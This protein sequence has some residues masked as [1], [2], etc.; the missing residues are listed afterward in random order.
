MQTRIKKLKTKKK[1]ETL[2]TE[3]KYFT[4]NKELLETLG[5]LLSPKNGVSFRSIFSLTLITSGVFHYSLRVVMDLKELE[6]L[7]V[8]KIFHLTCIYLTS[9]LSA[10]M[11]LLNSKHF[12]VLHSIIRGGFYTYPDGLTNEQ[13]LIRSR[14]NLKVFKISKYG[15]WFFVIGTLGSVLK[16]P[17]PYDFE[18]WYKEYAGWIP[19]VVNSWPRYVASQ[20]YHLMAAMSAALLGGSICIVFITIAEHLLA[21]LEI[22]CIEVDRVIN[23]IPRNGDVKSEM[24]VSS[25]IRRCIQHHHVILGYFM[26]FQLY[27]NIPLFF[28]LAATSIAMC[29]MAFLV[30]DPHS[31]FG[32]SVAFLSLFAPEIVFCFCYCTYGQKIAD[33]GEKLKATICRAPW[34][35]QSVPAQKALKM[36]L[37]RSQ[38]PLMLSASGFKDCSFASFG[39][40]IQTTYTYFNMLQVMRKKGNF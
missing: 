32:M 24:V 22:L 17:L 14:A 39:E 37:M 12:Y 2:S 38:R 3:P 4:T 28:F 5:L 15:P 29:T 16:E 30:T 27:F 25:R 6:L 21:Q 36:I 9:S 8:I 40:I 11:V 1:D 31:T 7:S 13:A 20:L 35:M 10:W 19:F 23:L 34:Y 18:E 26:T 33:M